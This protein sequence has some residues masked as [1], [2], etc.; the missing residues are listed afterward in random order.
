MPGTPHAVIIDEAL[1]LARTFST[2]DAV[3]FVNG[4]LDAIRRTVEANRGT[5]D[6][7]RSVRPR[8]RPSAHVSRGAAPTATPEFRG[9]SRARASIAIPYTSTRTPPSTRSS[10]NSAIA[11]RRGARRRRR[12]SASPAAC[13]AC[14]RFGKTDFWCCRTAVATSRC[15][16]G[17]MRCR[18]SI[19]RS[20]SCS[21]SAIR[22]ASPASVMRTKTNE[23][24]IWASGLTFLAKCFVPLPEKWHGLQ[25]IETRYR[26]RY[27]DL[28]VNPDSRRVFQVRSRVVKAMRDVL[29]R[30]GLP[31]SRDADDAADRGRRAGAAVHDASQRARHAAVSARSRRSSISS[32]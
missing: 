2:E 14:A 10:T 13:S 17:R 5:E 31:R 21:T 24:T 20:S 1:E 27:L 25:D 28:I 29:R 4:V 12:T 23:L 19:S 11:D 8:L 26:Q 22:L 30:R 3:K 6:E 9:A 18:S 32:G 16:C 7:S 15:T